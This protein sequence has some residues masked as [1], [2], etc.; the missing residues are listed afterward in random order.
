VLL[1]GKTTLRRES[2]QGLSRKKTESLAPV[3]EEEDDD[4]VRE[5]ASAS[6]SR[7][8]VEWR[9]IV[10]GGVWTWTSGMQGKMVALRPDKRG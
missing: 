6:A 9:V 1:V 3:V 8:V 2:R 5:R 10:C 7:I 4:E